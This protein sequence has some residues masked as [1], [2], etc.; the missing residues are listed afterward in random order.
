MNPD[1]LSALLP[2]LSSYLRICLNNIQV[3]ARLLAPREDREKDPALD[4]RAA[5]LDQGCY[6][7]IRMAGNLTTARL[8]AEDAPPRL[9]DCDLAA[10]VT[11]LFEEV[12]YLAS[13]QGL[14]MRL[15]C[16]ADRLVCPASQEALEQIF[17]NL[18]SNAVKFTPAGGVITVSLRRAY[19]R[20]LLTVEDT[21]PGIPEEAL[22]RVFTFDSLKNTGI[23]QPPPAGLGLGLPLCRSMAAA[24]GGTLMVESSLGKGSRFTL[25]LLDQQPGRVVLSDVSTDYAGGF[26]HALLGLA[27]A[28]PPQAFQIRMQ[29]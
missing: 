23:P 24:M 3:A 12:E 26:N 17:Y 2:H 20:V 18:I 7:L 5:L 9:Q 10:L 14:D 29:D 22:S 8:L 27:D 4:A 16:P 19:H 28:M 13:G 21:G 1:E 11:R 25:S 15:I 6:Q